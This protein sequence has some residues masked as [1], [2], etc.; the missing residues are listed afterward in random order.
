MYFVLLGRRRK[1]WLVIGWSG[2]V[3]TSLIFATIGSPEVYTTIFIVFLS[4]SFLTLAD[5]VTDT[6]CVEISSLE[7]SDVKGCFQATG[8]VYKLTGK[9]IGS[10]FGT[11]LYENGTVWSFDISEM[12]MLQACIPIVTLLVFI[13]PLD[14]YSLKNSL[15]FNSFRYQMNEVWRILQLRA[16]WKP[17]IFIYVFDVMQIPNA[18]WSNFLVWGL[19]FNTRQLGYLTI[20]SSLVGW[21]VKMNNNIFV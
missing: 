13:W 4:T 9:L 1:P 14:E 8:Y 21:M 2:L 12:F 10:I 5:V 15:N 17:L 16:V 19:K 20:A 11:Y 3:L 7:S 18:A 6:I